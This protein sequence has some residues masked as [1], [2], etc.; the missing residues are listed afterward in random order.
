MYGKALLFL[1]ALLLAPLH[2]F[3]A[4]QTINTVPEAG[5]LFLTDLQT[6]LR[7]EMAGRANQS[8]AGRT[9][10]GGLPSTD[11]DLSHQVPATV[12][13]AAGYYVS[14]SAQ[15][16]TYTASRRT[17]VYLHKDGATPASFSIT[18]GDGCTFDERTGHFIF[19]E[20]SAS[21]EA[22][23]PPANSVPLYYAD[24]DGSAITA[25]TDLR[26]RR[27]TPVI[28][29]RAYDAGDLCQTIQDAIAANGRGIYDGRGFYGQQWCQVD[30]LEGNTHVALLLGDYDISVAASWRPGSYTSIIGQNTRL[31]V[32]PDFGNNRVI[33]NFTTEPASEADRDTHIYVSGLIIDGDR[34]NNTTATEH[35]H[36]VIMQA[37]THVIIENNTCLNPKGDGFYVGKGDG[38]NTEVSE[39]AFILKN[40]VH[41]AFRN[42]VTVTAGRWVQV[43]KNILIT[44][45]LDGIDIEPDLAEAEAANTI[46]VEGNI[47]QGNDNDY[48]AQ[49]YA[50][51]ACVNNNA[52]ATQT[53]IIIKGNIVKDS[54]GYGIDFRHC[55]NLLIE[56]N[57]VKDVS[58]RGISS[59]S[60]HSIVQSNISIRNND[61]ITTGEQGL[62]VNAA[63]NVV[64]QNNKIS[65]AT[66]ASG[67][68][69]QL[70][71]LTDALVTSNRIVGSAQVGML[72][73]GV[74]DSTFAHNF[75]IDN[76][77]VGI[78]LSASGATNSTGNHFTGNRIQGNGSTGMTL[79]ASQN[80]NIVQVNFFE[81]NAAA[82]SNSGTGNKFH[83]NTGY[84]T[85]ASGT[86]TVANGA[87]TAVVTHGLSVTPAAKDCSVEFTESPTNATTIKYLSTFTSTQFTLNVND[88]GASALDFG[89]NCAVY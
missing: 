48:G 84:V 29:L 16:H 7:D 39:Y 78:N 4:T 59:V 82:V 79:A 63:T 46:L 19:V 45:G 53:N 58:L 81:G 35:S 72:I 41:E 88:P 69:M 37:V 86:G 31:T 20:C 5:E 50:G 47:I 56:G 2:L 13:Y 27:A 54:D 68:G 3:A 36:C 44:S 64:V 1:G 66:G 83:H 55:S 24:T 14:Q 85:E 21:S 10:S 17:F 23:V 15:D 9:V 70:V 67:N 57:L 60:A 8:L 32:I 51:I 80:S 43:S 87:T 12:G 49:V 75:S 22:P 73:Q 61:I 89:W 74:Q 52:S 28:D 6:F 62:V 38:A 25:V 40:S 11:S 30:P 34:D 77:G 76:T 65:G 26:W 18:G 71:L 33:H 42:G